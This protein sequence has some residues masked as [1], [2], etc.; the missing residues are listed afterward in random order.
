LRVILSEEDEGRGRGRGRKED[1]KHFVANK[2]NV[3]LF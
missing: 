1:L 3:L 2:R